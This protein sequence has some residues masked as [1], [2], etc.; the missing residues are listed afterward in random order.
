MR[1]K[2]TEIFQRALLSKTMQIT[3]MVLYFFN[4]VKLFTKGTRLRQGIEHAT[5]GNV[6]RETWELFFTFF[7]SEKKKQREFNFMFHVKH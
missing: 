1:G 7:F 5:N 3:E 4:F 6:S 2:K